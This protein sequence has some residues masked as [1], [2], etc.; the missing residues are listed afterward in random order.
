MRG[1]PDGPARQSQTKLY[2][3]GHYANYSKQ[4]PGENHLQ[5]HH[6][7]GHMHVYVHSP[8]LSTSLELYVNALD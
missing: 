4:G 5:S 3:E 1:G 7:N 6:G 8:T 2:I